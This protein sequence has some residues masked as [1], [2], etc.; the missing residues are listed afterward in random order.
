VG[1]RAGDRHGADPTAALLRLHAD[2]TA[3]S[4]ADSGGVAGDRVAALLEGIDAALDELL[5]GQ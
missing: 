5:R 4:R 1:G 2:V 3:L